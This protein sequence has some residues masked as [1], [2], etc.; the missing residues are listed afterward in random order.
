[1]NAVRTF[2]SLL[3]AGVVL[4]AGSA[5]AAAN[6]GTL[7]LQHPT[8]VA[9]NNLAT[10]NYTVQWEGSGDQVQ[11]KIFQ[12]KKAVAEAPA[13][14]IKVD[15]ASPYDAALTVNNGDGTSSLSQIRFRGKTFALEL[16]PAGGGSGAAGSAR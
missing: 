4:L 9:G 6:K 1:M 11:L 14:M 7:Q 12:G 13:R 15:N 2:K 10:G 5:F 16:A 8:N 3:L